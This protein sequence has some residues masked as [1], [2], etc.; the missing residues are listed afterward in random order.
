MEGHISN[1]YAKFITSR[2]HSYSKDGLQTIV[3]F[4][5]KF[6]KQSNKIINNKLKYNV[7]HI[8]DNSNFTTKYNYRLDHFLSKRI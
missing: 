8:I 1:K 4:I 2:P 3:Q 6:R 7:E 5:T